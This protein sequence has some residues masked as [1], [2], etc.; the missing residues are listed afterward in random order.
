[1]EFG[2]SKLKLADATEPIPDYGQGSDPYQGIQVHDYKSVSFLRMDP[3][4]K[5]ASKLAVQILGDHY[6]E[7]LSLKF[8]VNVPVFMQWMFAAMKLFISAET[9]KKFVVLNDSAYVAE[10]LGES[11]PK[12]HGGKLGP[13]EEVGEQLKLK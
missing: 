3:R 5:L 10:T 12:E 6:P 7:T 8:F 2:V 11:I 9:A 4:A 13:L 1:M